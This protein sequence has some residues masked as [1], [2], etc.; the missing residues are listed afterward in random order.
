MGRTAIPAAVHLVRDNPSKLPL[1]DLMGEANAPRIK[2][3]IPERPKNLTR[4]GAAEWDRI[5]PLLQASG[6]LSKTYLFAAAVYCEAFGEWVYL[7]TQLKAKY[8]T[9]GEKA[10]I[11]ETPSGYKQIAA[12]VTAR[13]RA[14]E[15]CLRFAKEFGLTPAT[16]IQSTAGQQMA[17]PGVPDDPMENF[18]AAAQSLP[19][20]Q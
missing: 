16:H 5:T 13:D 9:D 4:L 19:L 17:L 8:K 2:V 18:L 20:L 12:L 11:D 3:E 15:R 7:S 10:Y 6:L 1:A 14:S